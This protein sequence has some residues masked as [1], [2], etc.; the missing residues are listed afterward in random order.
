M[1]VSRHLPALSLLALAFAAPAIAQD[2]KAALLA[3]EGFKVDWICIDNTR[4]FTG[5]SE[6]AFKEEGGKIVANVNNF[7]RGTCK[8]DV[9]MGEAGPSWPG[10]RGTVLQMKFNTNDKSVPFT[11][12]GG[13]CTYEFRPR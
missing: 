11:G 2:V 4:R 10:C 3:P 8:S 13:D 1:K 12:A 7:S 6:V 9:T 5:R